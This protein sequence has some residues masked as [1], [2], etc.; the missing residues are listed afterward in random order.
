MALELG[1]IF[2]TLARSER[3]P[4]SSYSYSSFLFFFFVEVCA[5]FIIVLTVVHSFSM[6]WPTTA[7]KIHVWMKTIRM[8]ELHTASKRW[9]G[10]C[11]RREKR[12]M[13]VHMHVCLFVCV[14]IC[15]HMSV[16]PYFSMYLVVA[17]AFS[18]ISLSYSW[19]GAV[20]A[21]TFKKRGKIK[22]KKK[23]E[24]KYRYCY[25]Q[26]VRWCEGRKCL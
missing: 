1:W 6:H 26:R 7:I 12:F 17:T 21:P 14:W 19:L 9:R 16:H 24:E 5:S 13:G 11:F 4:S 3:G 23:K 25:K 15:F 10:T 2:S 18:H 8:K 22:N 20:V